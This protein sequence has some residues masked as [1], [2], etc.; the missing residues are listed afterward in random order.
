VTVKASHAKRPHDLA[1]QRHRL[2]KWWANAALDNKALN[3]ASG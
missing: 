3:A 2:R 1:T